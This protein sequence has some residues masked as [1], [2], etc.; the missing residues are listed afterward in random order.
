MLFDSGVAPSLCG[1]VGYRAY[2]NDD[3]IDGSSLDFSYDMEARTF[4][5]YSEKTSLIGA[6]E[7]EVQAFLINYPAVQSLF[8]MATIEIID[9]CL[10]PFSLSFASSSSQNSNQY[11]YTGDDPELVLSAQ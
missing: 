9:P 4:E 10:D 11:F 2:V 3:E 5:I 1:S 7:I 6:Q 8:E